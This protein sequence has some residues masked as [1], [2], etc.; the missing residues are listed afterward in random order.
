M[1]DDEKQIE[2]TS[3]RRSKRLVKESKIQRKADLR[4][5]N[6][7]LGIGTIDVNAPS[8]S[9][10]IRFDDDIEEVVVEEE[11]VTAPTK[12]K[13]DGD[14]DDEG[15]DESDDEVEEVSASTAK[16]QALQIRAAERETRQVE[17]AISQKRKRKKK[18][19]EKDAIVPVATPDDSDGS[20]DDELDEDFLA[21]VDS[22]RENDAKMKKLKQESS[23]RVNK[24]GRHTT[25]VSEENESGTKN[26]IHADHNIEVVV[27]PSSNTE[28]GG[29][30][31]DED[32][33][34]N[35]IAQE[36]AALALSSNLGTKASN[37]AL[38]FCRGR[39]PSNQTL[40]KNEKKYAVKRSRK[41]K[42]RLSAG[43]PSA[44]FVVKKRRS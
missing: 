38:L 13:G 21:M 23:L 33:Q 44:N 34:T 40:G 11:E 20:D 15:E 36:K 2:I 10:K 31:S 5:K 4:K 22:A 19:T 42:Y 16:N 37:T 24:L 41:M 25:F 12:E 17:S 1:S 9:N 30:G 28:E 27:L 7:G 43:R 14:E 39:Q 8:K 29:S 3:P 18:T 32:Q 26:P 35:I 6:L